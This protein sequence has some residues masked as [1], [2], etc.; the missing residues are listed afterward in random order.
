MKKIAISLIALAAL[1]TASFA[2]YRDVT[3][4]YG[5]QGE[6]RAATTVTSTEAL[7]I[8]NVSGGSLSAFE[9]MNKIAAENENSGH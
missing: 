8:P 6:K 2:S 4:P 9:R 1:S 3:T 7:A 5:A